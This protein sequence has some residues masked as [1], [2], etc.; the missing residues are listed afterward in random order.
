MERWGRIGGA[1]EALAGVDR[2]RMLS[3]VPVVFDAAGSSVASSEDQQRRKSGRLQQGHRDFL[4]PRLA[5]EGRWCPQP[6][7]PLT[8]AL[9]LRQIQSWLSVRW[10]GVRFCSVARARKDTIV[11]NVPVV[12]GR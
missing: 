8:R 12:C 6:A 11:S 3:L 5:P 1:D 4:P 2:A 7:L 10:I 9:E